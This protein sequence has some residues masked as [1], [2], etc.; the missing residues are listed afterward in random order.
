MTLNEFLDCNYGA[1]GDDVLRRMLDGGA[2]PNKREGP[3][4][5]APLH[6]ATRRRRANAVEI[7]LDRGPISTRRPAAGKPHMLTPCAVGLRVGE[8]LRNG[9]PQ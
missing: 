3:L 4:S 1:D 8:V 2:D 6:V 5:E 9:R 7:L